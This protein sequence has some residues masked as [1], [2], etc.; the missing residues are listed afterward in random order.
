MCVPRYTS[1]DGNVCC[2]WCIYTCVLVSFALSRRQK[3]TFRLNLIII[4]NSINNI[5][6]FSI[7][8]NYQNNLNNRSGWCCCCCRCRSRLRCAHCIQV[9][10]CIHR[11]NSSK[12]K[13]KTSRQAAA[14]AVTTGIS[15]GARES[16]I[17]KFTW[18]NHLNKCFIAKIGQCIAGAF[19][20]VHLY[21]G[22]LIITS[23]IHRNK[24]TTNTIY[25]SMSACAE[26]LQWCVPFCC[27][28]VCHC[29][30]Q[31]FE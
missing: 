3:L 29:L 25:N 1:G 12:M 16:L 23:S 15:A 8:E 7:Q 31:K 6:V 13:K 18:Q 10:M 4:E 20:E 27:Y 14:A 24:H 28:S 26:C 5:I 9:Y 30:G 21:I 22:S 17:E 11:I 19:V 2:V